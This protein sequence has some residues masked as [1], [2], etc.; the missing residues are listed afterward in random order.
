[1]RY[2]IEEIEQRL[3]TLEGTLQGARF[4][5]AEVAALRER[6][7][8]EEQEERDSI[9][10]YA[11][12]PYGALAG[13][14]TWGCPACVRKHFFAPCELRRTLVSLSVAVVRHSVALN[15][16]L[17]LERHTASRMRVLH[18]YLDVAKGMNCTRVERWSID[19]EKAMRPLDL[20]D[21]EECA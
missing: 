13:C 3:A 14:P 20:D 18:M 10:A 2:T 9:E 21:Y 4:R 12:S 6:V 5:S 15:R 8:R 17:A 7:E 1:V 16:A 11:T 19:I